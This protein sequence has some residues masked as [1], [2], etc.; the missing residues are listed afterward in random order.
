MVKSK[1]WGKRGKVNLG[2]KDIGYMGNRTREKFLEKK[3]SGT[4]GSRG[5]QKIRKYG[6]MDNNF[7]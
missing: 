2:K 3:F 1:I 4:L 7:S 5:I 6:T